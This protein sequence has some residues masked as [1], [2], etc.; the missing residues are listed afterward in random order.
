MKKLIESLTSPLLDL[1]VRIVGTPRVPSIGE[2][3]AL[4]SESPFDNNPQH[5]VEVT[6]IR[7]GWVQYRYVGNDH[8][9][10]M[11]I[12]SFVMVY[13]LEV[14]VRCDGGNDA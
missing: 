7:D 14:P 3:Y 13:E 1:W 5:V 11:R 9:S 2:V 8:R 10:S 12:S 6:D 4:Y